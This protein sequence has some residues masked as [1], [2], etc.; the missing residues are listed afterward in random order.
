MRPSRVVD[1]VAKRQYGI[2][3]IHMFVLWRVMRLFSFESLPVLTFVLHTACALALSFAGA[4]VV[5]TLLIGPVQHLLDAAWSKM[6]ASGS[7]G[8]RAGS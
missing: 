2:Y 1:V 3:I 6:R 8:A 5:E 4:V 7:K